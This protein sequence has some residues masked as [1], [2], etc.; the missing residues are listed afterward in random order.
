MNTTT[1]VTPASSSPAS[2]S[3]SILKE[4]EAFLEEK[5]HLIESSEA[6]VY[7]KTLFG[8]HKALLQKVAADALNVSGN[9]ADEVAKG[10][11]DV[12]TE[13]HA[14]AEKLRD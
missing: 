4:V 1:P 9:V 14:E 12:A 8:E 13:A 6:L 5:V 11:R 2:S 3:S 7:L 10:A